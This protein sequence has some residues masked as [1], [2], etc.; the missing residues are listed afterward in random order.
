[1]T[2]STPFASADPFHE[3]SSLI[4]PACARTAVPF[5]AFVLLALCARPLD[6]QSYLDLHDFAL[7][8][9]G[10]P[11]YPSLMAE[12][13]DNNIYGVT[14]TGGT[15][16]QGT[17]FKIGPT[18]GYTVIHNF[19][20]THGSTPIGGLTLGPDGN[21]YGM[22]EREGAHGFGN[23]FKITPAGAFTVVYSFTANADGGLPVSPLIVGSDG[24]FYGTSYPGA[25]F[26][27]TLD[28]VFQ[29]LAKTPTAS[30]GP[31]FE[32]T[33]GSFY[34]VTE[35]GG[36]HSAGAVYR[37]TGSSTTILH[38]FAEPTGCYPIGGL[39]EGA[40]GN[41]YGTT[42]A[43]GAYN[44]GVVY[45]I[46]PAGSYSVLVD[47]DNVHTLNGYEADAGLVAGADGN[48]YGATIWGGQYGYGVIFSM[49]TDGD[50]TVLHDFNVP[51][52]DGAYAT[53]IQH[54][55]G[56]LYGIT[57]RGGAAHN[58]VLYSFID[59]FAP[60]IQL[61]SNRA[62]VG[63]TVGILG[64]GFSQASSIEFNGTPASFHVI[65]N[66]FMTATVPSGETGFVRV[67]MASG[68]LL[69]SKVFRVTPQFRSITPLEGK[70]G[71]TVTFTG[72]GLIQ[73][74]TITVGGKTVSTFAVNS[75]SE[76]TFRVPTGAQTGRIVL[77]TPGG[78]ATSTV[79]FTVT[80]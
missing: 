60:F 52:G 4:Q 22:A 45:R 43:G 47:F 62:L 11:P 68:D 55:N 34:G 7:N 79:L 71:D 65:S 27:L 49:T 39:V 70:A 44:G 74:E 75:D 25:A 16:S 26:R 59:N 10:S 24:N 5:L 13:R 42:T 41:L 54:T 63:E 3:V 36:T 37:L 31:L 53:P 73:A 38:S 40:D 50:Y 58:G 76:V 12:G 2:R 29:V 56:K 17:I 67:N 9:G 23:I 46:T 32:A 8:S 35:F 28:G 15:H 20:G 69:S 72:T 77:K 48:L 80:P 61:T 1:M 57:N 14:A 6:A 19:D 18:G 64:R 78:T 33:N 21:L 51:Q 66:T 30:Y